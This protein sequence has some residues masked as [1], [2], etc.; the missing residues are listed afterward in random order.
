MSY[1]MRPNSATIA[2]P[3]SLALG[4]TGQI[5]ATAAMTALSSAAFQ[6]SS[7]NADWGTQ[8][9]PPS[10]IPDANTNFVA[11]NALI[12]ALSTIGVIV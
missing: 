9:V 1:I 6:A 8:V 3:I 7:V 12:N 5:T 2:T 4:G 10:P 11:I